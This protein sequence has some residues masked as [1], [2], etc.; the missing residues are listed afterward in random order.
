MGAGTERLQWVDY[1]KG[2]SILLVV[3]MHATLGVSAALGQSGIMEQIV[4][5]ASSFRMPLFFMLSGLFVLSVRTLDW[6]SF[7]DKRVLGLVYFF[8]LWTLITLIFKGYEFTGGDLS[9]LPLL[10]RSSLVEPIGTLWFIYVLA[11]CL[12]HL[13]GDT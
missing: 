8:L 13:E 3:H 12:H 11:L 9:A 5:F 10:A 7:L 4:H 6:K 1:A 2:L